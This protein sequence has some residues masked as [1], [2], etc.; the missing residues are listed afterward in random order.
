MADFDFTHLLKRPQY[1]LLGLLTCLVAVYLTVIWRIGDVSH[2]AMSI[3]FLLAA[4]TLIW[5]NYP[6]FHYRQERVA[7]LIGAGL[8]GWILWQSFSMTSQQQLQL[9]LF[10]LLSALAVALI[11]SG[12]RGLLQYRREFAIML[13]LGISG[14]SLNLVDPSPLTAHFA[15]LLLQ[16]RGFDVVQQGRLITLPVGTTEVPSHASGMESMS[17]LLGIA[18]ICLTLYP[19]AHFKK[20]IALTVALGTGFATNSI[21]VAILATLAAPQ[22]QDT[23]LYWYEGEGAL[24]CSVVAILFFVS[25]YWILHQ[26]ENWQKSKRGEL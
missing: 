17:Y 5:E 19:I 21:R 24:F 20:V 3:L 9:R 6:N 7:S 1:G 25:F 18:V 2:F 11:A 4:A 16:Y 13:F 22:D 12:F 15:S 14:L 8:I 10:P 23:F 26:I